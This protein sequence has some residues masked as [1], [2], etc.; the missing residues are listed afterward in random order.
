[1]IAADVLDAFG[2]H[3]VDM[4]DTE[5]LG[6]SGGL[7]AFNPSLPNRKAQLIA[8]TWPRAENGD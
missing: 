8:K 7:N 6:E 5:R 3:V 2:R 1:M 4:I